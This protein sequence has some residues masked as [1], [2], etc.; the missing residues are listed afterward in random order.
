MSK[1]NAPRTKKRRVSRRQLIEAAARLQ[2]G[3]DGELYVI[4]F[5]P[6][7]RVEHLLLIASFTMLALTGLAQRYAATS[8]GTLLLRLLGGIETSRQIHHI[9]ALLF[10]LESVYHLLVFVYDVFVKRQRSEILPNREDLKQLGEMLRYNLGKSDKHP[11]FGR[12]TFEEKMEYWAL[13]WGALVMGITGAMQWF[14]TLVARWLP[15]SVIPIA[16]AIHGWEAVLAVA[17]I[18]VWHTYHVLIKTRNTSMFTGKLSIAQMEEEHPAELEF[19]LWAVSKLEEL[20]GDTG[21]QKARSET[22]VEEAFSQ[23]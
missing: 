15:G 9:F 21:T 16:R 18:A 8:L 4:R 5:S 6:A 3:V 12:Y 19:I 14:P 23:A 20:Q 1:R 7:Q 10:F 22:V 13:V 17:T 2:R 11:H